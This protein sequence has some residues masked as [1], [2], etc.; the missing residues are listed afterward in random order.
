MNSHCLK[1]SASFFTFVLAFSCSTACAAKLVVSEQF[2]NALF[3]SSQIEPQKQSVMDLLDAQLEIQTKF[4][5]GYVSAI[6]AGHRTLEEG[7]GRHWFY[8][9]NGI[10]SSVGSQQYEVQPG[11]HIWWD[12]HGW[13]GERMVGAV[14]GAWPEPFVNGYGGEKFPTVI[15]ANQEFKEDAERIASEL[16]QSGADSVS[17]KDLTDTHA[18]DTENSLPI[19]VGPWAL[20]NETHGLS[21]IFQ[22]GHRLGLFVKL[23]NDKFIPLNWKGEAQDAVDSAGAILALKPGME[24]VNPLWLVTGTDSDTTRLAVNFLIRGEA[25][26]SKFSGVIVTQEGAI[27]VPAFN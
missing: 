7:D 16:R 25:G 4:G 17:V 9:V 18:V 11:D 14:I 1:R 2:G 15:W 8:Y 24:K 13:Q 10:L 6:Q 19:Y 5:G 22:N 23:E 21:E 3:E 20:L 12:F 27:N 26:S